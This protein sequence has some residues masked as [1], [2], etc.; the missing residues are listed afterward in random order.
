[1]RRRANAAKHHN[2]VVDHIDKGKERHEAYKVK[3]TI[4]KVELSAI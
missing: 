3:V 2:Q 1:M 4:A